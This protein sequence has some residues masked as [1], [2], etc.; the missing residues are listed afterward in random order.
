MGWKHEETKELIW[1]AIDALKGGRAVDA[2]TILERT[3]QPKWWSSSACAAEYA[4]KKAGAAGKA[5]D[6]L[7]SVLAE[8]KAA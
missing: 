2:L 3:A 5:E 1:E 4:E 8:Q 7:R 6:V